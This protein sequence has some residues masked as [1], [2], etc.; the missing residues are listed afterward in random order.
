MFCAE[1]VE[2]SIRYMCIHEAG[3][4]EEIVFCKIVQ[5]VAYFATKHTV[6]SPKDGRYMNAYI[7]EGLFYTQS[8]KDRCILSTWLFDHPSVSSLSGYNLPAQFP[9]Q[10][11]KGQ[12]QSQS[13]SLAVSVAVVHRRPS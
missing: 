1:S 5:V 13:Q 7:D 9:Q 2:C 3:L 4:F 12:S 6:H 11:V 10:R 8:I